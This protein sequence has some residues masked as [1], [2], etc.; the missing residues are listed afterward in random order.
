MRARNEMEFLA[1][2][3]PTPGPLSQSQ[4]PQR[5]PET[6]KPALEGAGFAW[7][8]RAEDDQAPALR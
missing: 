7:F 4:K 1:F 6:K 3:K 2:N 8:K 5:L